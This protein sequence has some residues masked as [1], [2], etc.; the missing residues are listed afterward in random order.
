MRGNGDLDVWR[1]K[2][3]FN[4][5]NVELYLCGD[6]AEALNLFTHNNALKLLAVL[7]QRVRDKQHDQA[8]HSMLDSDNYICHIMRMVG[9]VDERI[10]EITLQQCLV[11]ALELNLN[12]AKYIRHRLHVPVEQEEAYDKFAC[13]LRDPHTR[14]GAQVDIH[15]SGRPMWVWALSKYY[16]DCGQN[17]HHFLMALDANYTQTFF[18]SNTYFV[19]D[20]CASLFGGADEAI[21]KRVLSHLTLRDIT[22]LASV[23]RN[24]RLE[25]WT[26]FY[27]NPPARY[28]PPPATHTLV[29]L[30]AMKRMGVSLSKDVHK[31]I[32]RMAQPHPGDTRV[33]WEE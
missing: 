33:Y 24:M 4:S 31:M 16:R 9:M 14:Q 1:A 23:S 18:G 21:V 8:S 22:M 17:A 27:S 10:Y 25:M 19:S 13:E 6:A 5:L 29:W 28:A 11:A 2:D 3:Y 15:R 26:F 20:K 30:C 32:S 12:P 7:P